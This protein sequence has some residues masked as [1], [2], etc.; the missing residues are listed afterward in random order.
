M[1]CNNQKVNSTFILRNDS[2]DFVTQVGPIL[3]LG[4]SVI[5]EN[6]TYIVKANQTY[7]LTVRV[8]YDSHT[9]ANTT[10]QL[11]ENNNDFTLSY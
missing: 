11:G 7:S 3:H 2:N 6:L 5:T 10:Y 1:L 8:G 9:I 4:S